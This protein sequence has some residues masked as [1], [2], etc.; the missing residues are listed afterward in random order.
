MY[1]AYELEAQVEDIA[2]LGI[3]AGAEFDG[4]SQLPITIKKMKL[5]G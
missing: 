3:A 1:A 4:A 2:R 5:V